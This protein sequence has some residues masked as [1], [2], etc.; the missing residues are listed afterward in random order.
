VPKG[1]DDETVG[2]CPPDVLFVEEP[3][4]VVSGVSILSSAKV[5]FDFDAIAGAVVQVVGGVHAEE[6]SCTRLE[7][8]IVS[9]KTASMTPH[10]K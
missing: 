9:S 5:A 6:Q 8:A 7:H 2:E 10:G 4:E 3:L 1:L